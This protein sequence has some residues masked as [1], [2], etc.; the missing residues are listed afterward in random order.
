[1]ALWFPLYLNDLQIGTFYAQRTNGAGHPDSLGTYAVEIHAGEVFWRGQIRHRRRN[2]A[3]ALV[4]K[5]LDA[6]GDLTKGVS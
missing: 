3:F 2:G 1:M 4:Q 5:A 6:A